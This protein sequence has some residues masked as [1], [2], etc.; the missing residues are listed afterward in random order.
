MDENIIKAISY[1]SVV[2]MLIIALSLFFVL[3][4]SSS[5][6]ITIANQAITDKG[7]VYQVEK[8]EEGRIIVT[9]ADII[10]AIK[11][12]LETNIYVDSFYISKITDADLFN[13]SLFNHSA[14]YIMEYVIIETGEIEAVRYYKK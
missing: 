2:L 3:Y 14:L 12:G 13:Y 4:K 6:I 9:G 7:A 11:N 8:R 5:D 10:G 1:T